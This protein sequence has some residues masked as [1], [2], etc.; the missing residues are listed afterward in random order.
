[1]NVFGSQCGAEWRRKPVTYPFRS[2]GGR[3]TFPKQRSGRRVSDIDKDGVA[4]YSLYPDW[5]EGHAEGRPPGRRHAHEGDGA[6][7]GGLLREVGARRGRG[8]GA[9]AGARARS[10]A[11]S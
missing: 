8:R 9:E 11:L 5:V 10:S 7:R 4:H 6:T 2:Y 3:V 1:M